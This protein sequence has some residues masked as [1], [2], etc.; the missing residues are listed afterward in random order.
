MIAVGI[1]VSKSKH[2][3]YIL[4]SDGEVV[5]LGFTFSNDKKGFDFLLN[6]IYLLDKDKVK[7][8]VGIESTG[9]YSANLIS[10]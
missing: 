4:S 2:D 6:Q 10:F 3:C 5:N 8:K 7:V 9:H 1:D